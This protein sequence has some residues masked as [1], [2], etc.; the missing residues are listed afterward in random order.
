MTI[1]LKAHFL[2]NKFNSIKETME[3]WAFGQYLPKFS[4]FRRVECGETIV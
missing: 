4:C 3:S 1:Q 2:K